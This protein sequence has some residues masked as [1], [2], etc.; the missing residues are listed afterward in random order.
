MFARLL[1]GPGLALG[2]AGFVAL[3]AGL[4]AAHA[5]E[6]FRRTPPL[7][8][9][10]RMELVLPPVRTQ[11]LPNGLTVATARLPGASVVTIQVVIRAGEAD[12][13]PERPALAD[14]TARMIGKGT[15]MLSADYVENMI[16]SLGAEFSA[17][18]FMDYTVLTLRVLG[19]ETLLD[20]AIYI[21]R[22]MTLEASFTE[23]EL[24]AVRR[25]VFWELYEQKRVPEVLAWRQL[26]SVLFEGHSYRK[27]M[28]GEDT[29]KFITTRDVGGFYDRFYR[30][31]NA[32]VVVSG[33]IDE[34]V[35]GQ[36][37][38][39]HFSAWEGA[40]PERTPSPPPGPNERERICFVE[41]PDATDAFIY[42]GNVIMGSSDPDFFPFLV[43][44]Q[45]L[46]GTTRSRLFMNLRE[47]K[48][49]ASYAF[50][51][52]EVYGESGVYWARARV[53][54]EAI[55]PAVREI[56]GEIGALASGP[57]VPSEVEEAKSYL[58][59]NLPLRFETPVGFA[60]WMARYVA[61]R[62]DERQWDRGLDEIKR[63]D[64][65]RVRAAARAYLAARPVV[66][67]AGRADWLA[68]L[69][70][71]FP[72]IEVYDAGGTLKQTLGKGEGR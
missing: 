27:A 38:G 28:Y 58:V 54:P 72:R 59:G 41:A 65:D 37:I 4:P 44:K 7:P 31:G 19:E 49:Y 62:L 43:L 6:R 15:R 57:A 24:S 39:S 33:D 21:L 32:A 46:G 12:A 64:A 13:P 2:L 69:A 66:V 9:P 35:V 50:S 68:S 45:I 47:S 29:I 26:L 70:E 60:D 40:A 51:E 34:A 42:A 48:G 23:R 71:G 3:H 61:L 25:A 53:L 18:V 30:P 63:V 5:Q 56:L 55:V 16:E 14:I 20:R 52:M 11:V 22:L 36:R 67:V 17:A 10:Q 1:A 8:D